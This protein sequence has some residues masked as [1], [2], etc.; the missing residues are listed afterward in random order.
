[1]D[2]N[3]KNKWRAWTHD[4]IA[5]LRRLASENTSTPAIAQKLGR[6]Q[7]SIHAKTAKL[8]IALA[9]RKERFEPR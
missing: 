7:G 8:G 9:R 5:E 1:M 4:D 6:T 2:R 3:H